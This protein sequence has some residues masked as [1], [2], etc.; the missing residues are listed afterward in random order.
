[1]SVAGN[2]IRFSLFLS[3]D[4]V[5]TF[6]KRDVMVRY[7]FS[8]QSVSSKY[9]FS[10]QFALQL[11]HEQYPFKEDLYQSCLRKTC[12]IRKVRSRNVS[13]STVSE[14]MKWPCP[15]RVH[16]KRRW[17]L[18]TVHVVVCCHTFRSLHYILQI[19]LWSALVHLRTLCKA[20]E[21]DSE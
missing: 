5:I 7:L 15:F 1:M 20:I 4:T 11:N 10:P 2:M 8:P 14:G 3:L 18:S 16:C 17:L 6:I 19:S 13:I 12:S 21:V 9:L